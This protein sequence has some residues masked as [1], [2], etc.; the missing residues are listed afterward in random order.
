MEFSSQQILRLCT[1]FHRALLAQDKVKVH[2]LGW[3]LLKKK[4]LLRPG[5]ACMALNH[6]AQLKVL[7]HDLWQGFSDAL[8]EVFVE[9]DCKT[10]GLTTNAYARAMLKHD[11]A[12]QLLARRAETLLRQGRMQGRHMAM[13]VNG[14]SKLRVRD[15]ALMEAVSTEVTSSAEKLNAVDL[16][17]VAN[18][19]ARLWMHDK[20]VL[21]ALREPTMS[22]LPQFN[23]QNIAMII[24]AHGRFLRHD[25][26]L[27]G[28][29]LAE[30]RRRCEASR[31][32]VPAHNLAPIIHAMATRL[33]WC[34]PDF[35]K[36]VDMSLPTAIKEMKLPDT[37]LTVAGLKNITG[38]HVSQELRNAV[39]SHCLQQMRRFS[40]GGVVAVLELA[41]KLQHHSVDF[42][43]RAL[44]ACQES[45]ATTSW[46]PANIASLALVLSELPEGIEKAELVDAVAEMAQGL[47][48]LPL[49]TLVDLAAAFARLCR[50]QA[51]LFSEAARHFAR[52][53]AAPGEDQPKR[54]LEALWRMSPEMFEQHPTLSQAADAINL[55]L[56]PGNC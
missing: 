19:Y 52:I 41:L 56:S 32:V 2:S 53:P 20:E 14:F 17:S 44:S 27:L 26:E 39:F 55:D 1:L 54:L 34:T 11:V 15:E 3:E 46:E 43:N 25:A 31:E 35:L 42:W 51:R 4:H 21:D 37:F 45:L 29:L 40:S 47:E 13:I 38:W 33:S 12:F 9:I 23:M 28:A 30:L 24:H 36:V 6:F 22:A 5:E 18:G 49:E 10:L 16:A 8:P 50:P 7:D 48:A